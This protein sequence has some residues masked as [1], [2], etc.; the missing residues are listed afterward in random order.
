[1]QETLVFRKGN[2]SNTED[3]HGESSWQ[4]GHVLN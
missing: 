1:M 2:V 3:M 4:V